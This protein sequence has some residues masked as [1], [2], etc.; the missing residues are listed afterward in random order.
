MGDFTFD[1]LKCHFRC[2]VKKENLYLLLVSLSIYCV[3][4]PFGGYDIIWFFT[5]L[6]HTTWPL[7][8]SA[9]RP[10][11]L[12]SLVTTTDHVFLGLPLL[13]GPMT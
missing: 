2:V 4:P 13:P 6:F 7:V 11:L 8:I 10:V 1:T 12:K 3:F 5:A 9:I